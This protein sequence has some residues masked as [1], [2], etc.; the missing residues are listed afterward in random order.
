[1]VPPSGELNELIVAVGRERD[2]VIRLYPTEMGPPGPTGAWIATDE[3]D[4]IVYP[5][6]ASPAEHDMIICHELAH[7][8]LDHQAD[9]PDEMHRRMAGLVAPDIDPE[10]A[11]RFFSRHGYED[12]MEAEAEQLAT[13]LVTFMARNAAKRA[14]RADTLSERLR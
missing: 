8:L 7:M 13:M 11:I 4:W 10:V 14:M 12:D 6:D 9:Q 5:A 3:T 2:R 1:M